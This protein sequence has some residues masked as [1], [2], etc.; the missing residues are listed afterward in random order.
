MGYDIGMYCYDDKPGM[1]N[2][3]SNILV[4]YFFS[5]KTE[6]EAGFR[7]LY[8]HIDGMFCNLFV[9]CC[10]MSYPFQIVKCIKG[11]TCTP[12]KPKTESYFSLNSAD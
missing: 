5:D 7:A 9:C 6:T 3:T 4:L 8:R 11:I 12:L 10:F 2:T 1:T